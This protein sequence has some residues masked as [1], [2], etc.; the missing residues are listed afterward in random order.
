MGGW[1]TLD[2]YVSGVVWCSVVCIR[3]DRRQIVFG[4]VSLCVCVCVCC[5]FLAQIIARIGRVNYFSSRECSQRVERKLPHSAPLR[6]TVSEVKRERKKRQ[7]PTWMGESR[8]KSQRNYSHLTT[9]LS[10]PREWIEQSHTLTHTGRTE[11]FAWPV[12]KM[13]AFILILQSTR[14]KWQVHIGWIH[15]SRSDDMRQ[16]AVDSMRMQ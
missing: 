16:T 5:C 15:T 12:E 11:G 14:I 10:H 13:E 7:S 4:C 1:T 9:T 3:F 6:S 2:E 8:K